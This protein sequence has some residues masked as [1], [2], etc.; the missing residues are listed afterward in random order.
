MD[1][2]DEHHRLL[3]E[4]RDTLREQLEEYKRITARSLEYQRRAVARQEQ[5]GRLY[6]FALLV[7]ALLATGAVVYLLYLSQFIGRR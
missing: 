3:T 2:G 5:Q 7:S 4:I 1:Q 6:Q